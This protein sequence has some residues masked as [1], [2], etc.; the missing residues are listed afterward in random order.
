MVTSRWTPRLF[1]IS[2]M[3]ANAELSI[4]SWPFFESRFYK[5]CT[6]VD[7]FPPDTDTFLQMYRV[8]HIP[9]V[10]ACFAEEP[11]RLIG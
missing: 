6:S 10:T 1:Y 9:Y 4:S 2:Y 7:D 5:I 3:Y 8:Y 11:S